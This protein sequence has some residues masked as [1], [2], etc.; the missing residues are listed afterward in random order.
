MEMQTYDEV[1][2]FVNQ[3]EKMSKTANFYGIFKW[4]NFGTPGTQIPLH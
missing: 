2:E 1:L 4:K 3:C